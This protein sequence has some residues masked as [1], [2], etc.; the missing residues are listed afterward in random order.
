MV[1]REVVPSLAICPTTIA[2]MEFMMGFD[3]ADI[4]RNWGGFTNCTI[5]PTSSFVNSVHNVFI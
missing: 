4:R 3:L 2:K 1:G 5:K